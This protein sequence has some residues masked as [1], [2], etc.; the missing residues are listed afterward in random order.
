[1]TETKLIDAL[2]VIL[3]LTNS[4]ESQVFGFSPALTIKQVNQIASMALGIEQEEG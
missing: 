2:R 4:S 1:M 3:K